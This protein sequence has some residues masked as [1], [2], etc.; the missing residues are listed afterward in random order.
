MRRVYESAIV[1]MP[2]EGRAEY[3]LSHVA[4]GDRIELRDEPTNPH[5]P[6]AIAAFHQGQKIGYLRARDQWLRRYMQTANYCSISVDQLYMDDEDELTAVDLYIDLDLPDPPRPPPS[7]TSEIGD[8]LRLLMTVAVADGKV[9]A[10]EREVLERFAEVRAREV[11]LKPE[12]DDAARA[13]KWARRKVP[14]S[15]ETAQIIGRLSINRPSAF[16]AILEVAEIV[17]EIDGKVVEE[18]KAKIDSLRKLI[19]VGRRIS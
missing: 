7:I 4:T 2:Y 3:V 1:G 12:S 13:I 17:A 5:D 10:I 15:A 8:E 6:G 11:G 14:S 16:D 18:E 19:A 9:Q